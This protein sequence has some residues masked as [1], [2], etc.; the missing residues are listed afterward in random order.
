MPFTVIAYDIVDDRRRNKVARLLLDYG[1]RV[2]LSVFE[3]TENV[4]VI[5]KIFR[6]LERVIDA[7]EDSIRCYSLCESCIKKIETRGTSGMLNH[8]PDF[9]IILSSNL[10]PG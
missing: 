5:R 4:S 10:Y 2:Q 6:D 9:V 1:I 3:C 7:R 8:D